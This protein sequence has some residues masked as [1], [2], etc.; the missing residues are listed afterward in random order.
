MVEAGNPEVELLSEAATGRDDAVRRLVDDYGP[1]VFGFVLARVGGHRV[2]A[3]DVVQDT[4]I[5]A[6]RSASTFRG[7]AALSTWLCAIARRR[8]A[9]HYAAE[10]RQADREVVPPPD[11][12]ERLVDARDEVTRALGRLSALHRQVLVLK[13]LDELTVLEIASE[14]DRTAVQIQSLLQRARVALRAELER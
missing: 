7:D 3:D 14:L 11:D 9:R 10:R 6:M 1:T 4:F 13:Y 5:E 2:V 12:A 8:V